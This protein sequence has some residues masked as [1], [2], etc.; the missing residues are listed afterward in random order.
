MSYILSNSEKRDRFFLHQS[1]R[2]VLRIFAIN[3]LKNFTTNFRFNLV[4]KNGVIL[5]QKYGPF[6]RPEFY[7]ISPSLILASATAKAS[8]Y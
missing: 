5:P 1:I 6:T 4:K 2:R 3:Y 7:G 8:V